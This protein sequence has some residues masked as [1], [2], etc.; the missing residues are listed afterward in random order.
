MMRHGAAGDTVIVVGYELIADT[1]TVRLRYVGEDGVR[2]YWLDEI[3]A[4]MRMVAGSIIE[5]EAWWLLAWDVETL[6]PE[7]TGPRPPGL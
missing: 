2:D 6:S 4:P 5:G 3:G 1:P 7:L